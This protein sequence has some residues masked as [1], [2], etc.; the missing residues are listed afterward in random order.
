[1]ESSPGS[2]NIA[3]KLSQTFARAATLLQPTPRQWP[4]EWGTCREYPPTSGV[5]GQRDPRL[6][7]FMIPFMRAVM[8]G[9]ARRVVMVCSAQIGKTEALF[10]IIGERLSNSP[11]PI[12][13]VGP[14]KQFLTDQ[15]EPR[16][17]ELFEQAPSLADKLLRG[18]KSKVLRKIVAGVPIRLAHAGSS[19]ALKSDPAGLAISDE[20]DEMLRNVK[21]QGDPGALIDRRGETQPEF[22]HAAVST[23][24]RGPSDVVLDPESGL[25]F[26]R[27]QDPSEIESPIWKLWQQGT[28]YHWAWPCPH[29]AKYFIPRFRNLKWPSKATPFQALSSTWVECPN[30]DGK[31]KDER[32][33]SMNARGWFVAPGQSI[34]DDGVVVGDPPEST[35]ISFWV[36]GLATPFRTFGERAAEYIEAAR[37]GDIEKVQAVVNSG[38]GE[39]WAPSGGEV[40]EWQE[41]ANIARKSLY[42]RGQVPDGAVY[43][44]LTCDVQKSGVYWTKRA[45]GARATSWL[46]DYG[47]LQGDTAEEEIWE[48]VADL[49][50]EPVDEMPIRLGFIDSGFRPGKKDLLPI[51]RIYEF[52]R[53]FQRRLRP[54]KGASHVMR[55]PLKVSKIEVNRAGKASKYGLD[56]VMLDSGHWKSWVHERIRWPADQLGAWH[57]P[58]DIDDDY[59]LQLVSEARLK[60]PSGGE[61]WIQK[62]KHNHYLD[63]EAMQAAAGFMLNVQRLSPSGAQA[64][65]AGGAVPQVHDSIAETAPPPPPSAKSPTDNWLDVGDNWL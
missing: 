51:N 42:R 53:R 1:M 43:A 26:W 6:T 5:P 54:T 41:I 58:I 56:L 29:C 55:T 61:Q 23:P 25:E 2:L 40:P 46:I 31:I 48:A 57:L 59:A 22:V 27:D 12:L 11:V 19:T 21:K 14:N 24:S 10:D 20:V 50:T 32:K 18:K 47:F 37:S 44:T 49:L 60:K 63:C 30:C 45:W 36:G 64:I 7:P 34:T 52:C 17:M 4:D 62:A 35:T 3:P 16:L 8:S 65:A 15:L 28:K 13:Y 39:L 38:F 33:E 9:A